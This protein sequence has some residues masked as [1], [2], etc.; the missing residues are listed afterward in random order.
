[1]G[2]FKKP[3]KRSE[4]HDAAEHSVVEMT[5]K[6]GTSLHQHPS[7][8]TSD[9]FTELD[10]L[11]GSS[12]AVCGRLAFKM[13]LYHLAVTNFAKSL[14]KTPHDAG[15]LVD[16]ARALGGQSNQEK[17]VVSTLVDAL[18]RSNNYSDE[19]IWA[20]LAQSYFVLQKPEDAFQSVS[21]AI[22][23]HETRGTK[24]ADLWVLQSRILLLWMDSDGKMSLETL[25][26]YFLGA[27]QI[28]MDS[29]DTKRELQARLSLAQLYHRFACYTQSQTE[30]S[31]AFDLIRNCSSFEL[32]K[33]IGVLAR[34]YLYNFLCIIKF[35]LNQKADAY[36]V[37]HEA[38]NILP[39][40]SGT[41]RLLATL[42]QFYMIDGDLA[43]LKSLI[44]AMILEKECLAANDTTRLYLFSWLLGRIFDM[45]DDTKQSYEYY[46]L[47]VNYKPQ[48]ASL[49]IGIGSLYLRMGQ[50]EDAHIAFSHALN[51]SSKLENFEHP[52]LLRFNRLFAAFAWVG[53]SQV[54]IGTFRKQN[55]LDAL[56]QAS[57]LFT[58][59]GDLIHARHIERIFSDVLASSNEHSAYI[60]MNVPPQILLELFLYYDAGVF[61]ADLRPPEVSKLTS[62]E[63]TLQ[64][65]PAMV[66]HAPIAASLTYSP[67]PNAPNLVPPQ[68]FQ[69]LNQRCMNAPETFLAYLPPSGLQKFAG[70]APFNNIQNLQGS[71]VYNFKN[72]A[73]PFAI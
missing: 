54:F 73:K 62:C 67:L 41:A 59:E 19:R 55:A 32:P 33:P 56:R 52:F 65:M 4:V 57:V 35:K 31:Q 12:Y 22:A 39:Q 60:I 8:A 7:F 27:V 38:M 72:E 44:P 66:R 3:K 43:N 48:S 45:L 58:S 34:C 16:F 51:Y 37:L 14:E 70:P 40:V 11:L 1:M 36:S 24:D 47:A 28:A 13:G 68:V 17:I 42:A 30:V 29:K 6:K 15:I 69:E 2:N 71:S 26:P 50:F 18:Q 46:Q 9:K 25:T 23:A 20:Q 64:T 63:P 21:R 53:L 10:C 5:K 49:W 61:S